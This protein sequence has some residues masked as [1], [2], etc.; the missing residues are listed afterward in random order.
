MACWLPHSLPAA[1]A[2]TALATLVAA[3]GRWPGRRGGLCALPVLLASLGPPAPERSWP[4][5]GPVRV[6][7]TIAAVQFAPTRGETLVRLGTGPAPL[8]LH[9]PGRRELLPGD[10]VQA[11]AHLSAAVAPD[12]EPT[13]H[14]PPGGL[15]LQPGSPSLPRLWAWLHQGL[16]R[17]LL[18][19]V[20]GDA[21]V[22]LATLAL[23]RNTKAPTELA[24]H[25]RNTGL[26]HLL[27]VSGAHAAMLGL[28]L[29]LSPRPR[30]RL[31]RRAGH[32]AA[33]V[34]ALL[35]YAAVTGGEPPVVRSALAALLAAFAALGHRQVGSGTALVAPAL[36]TMLM[37]PEVLG[38]PSF[39]LSYTAVFGLLLAR[40]VGRGHLGRWVWT[41]LAA[42]TWATLVTAPLTLH[43]FGQLAPWAIVLTPLLAPLVALLLLGSLLGALLA[44]AAPLLAM[45]FGWLLPPLAELY[46]GCVQWADGLPGTPIHAAAVPEPWCLGL[47]LLASAAALE[48]WRDRRGIATAAILLV[49][50]HFTP[51]P[52][53]GP[54][55]LQLFA[56]GHG[57]SALYHSGAGHQVAID[58]GS[59]HQP[60]R[61][62]RLLTQALRNRRLDALVIT[63]GDLDHHN[64]VP[65]L[66][67]QVPIDRAILPAQ[68]SGGRL[69]GELLAA[70]VPV[71][72]LPPGASTPV[73]PGLLAFAPRAAPGAGSNDQSLWLR[74]ER[75]GTK[76]LLTGDAEALGIAA[77]LADGVAQQADV[78]VLPHHG[79]WA[80][81]LPELLRAVRPRACLASAS[82]VDG[83]TAGGRAARR[84]GAQLWA[85]GRHGDLTV[86]FAPAPRV[87][88]SHGALPLP[89]QPP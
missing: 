57:Q 4:R 34:L 45:P 86:E 80:P 61:A 38:T 25:H 23:G 31:G 24:N 43:W 75:G 70:G 39:L 72:L 69:H 59:L 13:L 26:S 8:W 65:A 48:R 82:S 27:A 17:H 20:P 66:L 35:V 12:L 50:P 21:G 76:V 2:W 42:S 71:E 56:V 44:W 68:L 36:L 62:S 5:P 6:T 19:L 28:L 89:D 84:T 64:G 41:P 10:R 74:V 32:L 54:A 47:A 14:V 22:L 81:N 88:G 11:V 77:A 33:A 58:C 67:A 30:Q 15:S 40:P 29:G 73:V 18:Q 49:L 9:L 46:L 7:G 78:L 1:A 60:G 83:D 16:S 63:H 79:R 53:N 55:R 52:D 51:L 85:T 3:Y 87:R 37:A